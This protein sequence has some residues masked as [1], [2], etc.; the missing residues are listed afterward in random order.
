MFKSAIAYPSLFGVLELGQYWSPISERA[1]FFADGKNWGNFIE[2]STSK[3]KW[4]EPTK[5]TSH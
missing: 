5:H 3:E 2:K 4:V 1:N